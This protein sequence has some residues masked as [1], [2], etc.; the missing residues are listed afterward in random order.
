[1][2]STLVVL[3]SLLSVGPG[4][5]STRAA[6]SELTVMTWNLSFGTDLSPILAATTQF[7][8]VTAVS[9]AY[10]QARATDFSGRAKAW[11]DEIDRARPDLVGLQA[12]VLWRT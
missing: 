11:A 2:A 7:E 1:M 8:F 9:A 3:A 4:T 10:A 12:A 6:G 5:A